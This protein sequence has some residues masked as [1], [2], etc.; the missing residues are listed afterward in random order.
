MGEPSPEAPGSLASVR[1]RAFPNLG[2]ALQ[3][4]ISQYP[5]AT[6]F[7]TSPDGMR[8]AYDRSGTGPAIVLLHGGGSMRQEWHEAGYVKRLQDDFTVITIDL[9]GHGESA[10]PVDPADYTTDKMGQDI[11]A[12]AD[13]CGVGRFTIWGMSFGGKVGRYLA[14]QS[15]R[16]AKIILMGTPLGLGVSGELRQDAKVFCAHWPPIVQAQRDGALDLSSL[17]QDDQNFL[18]RFNVPVVLA[19]VRAMLDW[20]T[21]EPGDFHCPTLWLVGSEDKHAMASIKE[22]EGSLGGT[23]VHV[24]IVEGLGH[25]QVFE[26]TDRVL[27]PMLTFTLS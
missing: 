5:M 19:W 26:A 13:A 9:R 12:V 20:P 24:H 8:V 25:D 15:E 2:L 1:W 22:Y 18:R 4:N 6:L 16:V 11:L 10:M 3:S 7:T 23:R 14:A 17:S 27:A 21:I